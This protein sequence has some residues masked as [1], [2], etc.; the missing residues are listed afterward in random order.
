MAGPVPA[1]HAPAP[2]SVLGTDNNRRLGVLAGLDPAIHENTSRPELT[3]HICRPK[4]IAIRVVIAVAKPRKL[5]YH[6]WC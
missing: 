4:G 2:P 3:T 5:C 1:I 6:Y